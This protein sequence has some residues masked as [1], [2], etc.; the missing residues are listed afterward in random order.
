[1]WIVEALQK[2]E[3]GEPPGIWHLVARSDEGG[4]TVPCCQHDHRSADEAS[5]CVEAQ[6]RSHRVTGI[7]PPRTENAALSYG[8]DNAGGVYL[9]L[10]DARIH[11]SGDAVHD[12]AAGLMAEAT[13][14]PSTAPEEPA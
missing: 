12:L 3:V 14:P 6:E 7:R 13:R 10:G 11:L 1:M 5:A 9:H 2:H 4:G 8:S